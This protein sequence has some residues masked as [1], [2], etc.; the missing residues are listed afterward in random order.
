MKTNPPL[1][2]LDQSV[3]LVRIIE[4][5]LRP[6]Q[7]HAGLTGGVLKRG[8]SDKDVDIVIYPDK[9]NAPDNPK[10]E[11]I[12]REIGVQGFKS[13]E[14]QYDDKTIY[15]GTWDGKRVDFFFLT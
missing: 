3:T 4:E 8:F 10:P 2:T 15:Q 9:K 12:L 5:L 7:M 14:F 6:L 11:V 13:L 1:W